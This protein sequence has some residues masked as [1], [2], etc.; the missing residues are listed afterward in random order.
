MFIFGGQEEDHQI[1]KVEDCRLKSVGQLNF[2]MVDGACTNVADEAVFICFH[3]IYDFST[4]KKCWKASQPLDTFKALSLYSTYS[5][6][7]T[8]IGNN[9]GKLDSSEIDPQFRK[10]TCCWS[11]YSEWR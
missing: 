10:N 1:S 8:R 6:R 2:R 3:D 4:G 9:G 7:M 11:K 5:H